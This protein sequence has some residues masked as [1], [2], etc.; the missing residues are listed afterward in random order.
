MSWVLPVF[1]LWIAF[2][3]GLAG[4][5]GRR[6]KFGPIFQTLA[7]ILAFL[8]LIAFLWWGVLRAIGAAS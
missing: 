2:L 5:F 3:C 6:K 4:Y 8:S 1:G 7:M